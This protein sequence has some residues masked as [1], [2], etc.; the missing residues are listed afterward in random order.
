ME[1]DKIELAKRAIACKNWIWMPGMR[2]QSGLRVVVTWEAYNTAS[3]LSDQIDDARSEGVSLAKELPELTDSATLGCLLA[4]V[5]EAWGMPT[6]ITV[7]YSSDEG[8]WGVS[9]SGATHGGWCG[10]GKTEAEALINAL[11]NATND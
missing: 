6:G 3:V 4:L 1:S 8:S 2:T 7:T 9:W 5:R 10:R 11:E